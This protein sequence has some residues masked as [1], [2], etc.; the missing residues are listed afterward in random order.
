MGLLKSPGLRRGFGFLLSASMLWTALTVCAMPAAECG[1][2]QEPPCHGHAAEDANPPAD[3]CCGG[4]HLS[5]AST[6]SAAP[7]LDA[8]R[9]Q[10]AGLTAPVAVPPPSISQDRT[11]ILSAFAPAYHSPPPRPSLGRAPPA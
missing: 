9:P 1:R 4:A 7:H 10:A 3:N 5:P 2:P 11:A 6:P 8:V